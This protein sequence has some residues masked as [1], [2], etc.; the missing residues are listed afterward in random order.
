MKKAVFC[1]ALLTFTL[2]KGF[3]QQDKDSDQAPQAVTAYAKG[4]DSYVAF[5]GN[6]YQ[7]EKKYV[8]FKVWKEDSPLTE[9]ERTEWALLK[10]PLAKKGVE[11]VMV[12]WKTEED[13]KAAFAK[14]GLTITATDGK[15]IR[16]QNGRSQLNTTSSKAVYVIENSKPVTLCSGN[17][18]EDRVKYFF[19]LKALN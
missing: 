19:G 2:F 10:E 5:F 14:Y 7:A 17:N 16:L 12:S 13:L 9:N 4:D 15:H 18:C 6:T 1:A 11:L 3:A 8:V